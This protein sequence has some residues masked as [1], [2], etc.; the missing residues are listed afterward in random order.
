MVD[1]NTGQGNAR[2]W[3]L[4]LLLEHFGPG[5]SLIKTSSSNERVVFAQGYNTKTG[6]RKI[7]LINKTAGP[8]KVSIP[9]IAGGRMS[10]VDLTTNYNPPPTMTL[11]TNA[12]WLNAFAVAIITMST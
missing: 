8:E 12:V 4:K 9:N 10:F 7:L 6:A 11:Q 3:I 1:W 5:D 2:Y